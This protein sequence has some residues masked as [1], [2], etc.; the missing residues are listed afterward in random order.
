MKKNKKIKPK[1]KKEVKK[2]KSITPS[3]EIESKYYI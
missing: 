3:K 2:K 1:S